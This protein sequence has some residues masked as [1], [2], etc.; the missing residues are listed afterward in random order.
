MKSL[1]ILAV[2]V[3]GVMGVVSGMAQEG[4][5]A[6]STAVFTVPTL[7]R[8]E[9]STDLIDFGALT[10]D[11]YDL[12]YKDALGAQ[13]VYVWSNRP[14]TLSVAANSETWTGPWEK[15][16]KDLQLRVA[17]VNRPERITY[18]M[19]T[20]TGLSTD[21]ITLAQG[22]PGGNFQH[23]MDFRVLVSWDNDVAGDY[24]LGFKY[25]LTAP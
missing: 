17:A 12:G 20:L 6:G 10:M 19:D 14:W 4:V 21:V 18:L 23:T 22:L 16:S 7:I 15:P 5:T 8:L 25:T 2:L 11:D 24:S 3:A 13:I 1:K 9:L